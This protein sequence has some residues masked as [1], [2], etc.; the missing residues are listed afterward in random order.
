MKT[1][2]LLKLNQK[3][4]NSNSRPLIDYVDEIR[5]IATNVAIAGPIIPNSI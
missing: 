4:N 1:Q 3:H 5:D 2:N